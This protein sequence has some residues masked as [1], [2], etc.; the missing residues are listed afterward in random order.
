MERK[1]ERKKVKSLSCVQLLATPWTVDY[2]GPLSVGFSMEWV[3][4]SFSRDLPNPWIKPG[5]PALQADALL[6]G[7]GILHTE[8]ILHIECSTFHSIIFQDLE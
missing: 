2:Q 4:M 5:S 6:P 7:A 1:K 8:C 3:A